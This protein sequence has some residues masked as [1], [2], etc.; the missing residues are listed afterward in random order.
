MK[1]LLIKIFV[2]LSIILKVAHLETS[3]YRYAFFHFSQSPF[4]SALKFQLIWL[5]KALDALTSA[6]QPRW[7]CRSAISLG[8]SFILVYQLCRAFSVSSIGTSRCHSAPKKP[9]CFI[10]SLRSIADWRFFLSKLY[11]LFLLST[12]FFFFFTILL[13]L[14]IFDFARNF[15]CNCIDPD[16]KRFKWLLIR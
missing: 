11:T 2:H 13:F 15:D 4:Q 8:H 5:S 9:A 7:G 14:V 16:D 3:A 10:G 6:L 1:K 12:L